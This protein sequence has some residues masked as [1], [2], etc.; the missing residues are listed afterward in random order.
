MKLILRELE[1]ADLNDYLKWKHPS[2][3]FR[4]YNG[5]YYKQETEKE[6]ED[7]I[8]IYREKIKQGDQNILIDKKIIA[9]KDTDEVIGEVNWYWKSEETLWMELW[10]VIFNE[11]YWG[12]WIGYTAMKMWID[13]KFQENPKLVR[14]GL[15]TW[16]G[17]MRMIRLA[18]KLWF[19]KEAVYRKARIINDEYFDSI[20]YGVLREEWEE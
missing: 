13:E 4:K 5:P 19:Q 14:L 1:L 15:S 20:S 7:M 8:E 11:H 2:R 16:S 3:E 9:N 18:E 6:L 12:Q 10:I 17:N